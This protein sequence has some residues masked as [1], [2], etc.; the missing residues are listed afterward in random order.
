MLLECYC[1]RRN[2][3]DSAPIDLDDDAGGIRLPNGSLY[4]GVRPS[5]PHRSRRS[6][7]REPR[8]LGKAPDCVLPP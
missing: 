3:M 7:G 6:P 5:R 8:K 4:V 2:R 1:L